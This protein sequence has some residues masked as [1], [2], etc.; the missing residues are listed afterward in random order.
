MSA[1]EAEFPTPET[2]VL[3]E[4]QEWLR[5]LSENIPALIWCAGSDG[6]CTYLNTRWLTFTGR[7]LQESLGDKWAR[8][9]HADDVERV[10]R[11]YHRCLDARRKFRLEYRLRYQGGPYKWVVDFGAPV[12]GR[13]GDFLGFIGGCIDVSMIHGTAVATS[14]REKFD[15]AIHASIDQLVERVCA[16]EV[17]IR[18]RLDDQSVDEMET[19]NL[20]E[21]LVALLE[22]K[23]NR[24]PAG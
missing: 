23:R 2:R 5:T 11:D 10:F 14:W 22:M 6:R 7:T 4:S 18:D 13:S 21:S 17:A 8:D 16:A 3:I 19:Q 20:N 1:S 9:V 24:L 15:D 12:F